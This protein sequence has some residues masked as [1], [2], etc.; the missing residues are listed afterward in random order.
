MHWKVAW[1]RVK[2][3]VRMK[4]DTPVLAVNSD[5]VACNVLISIKKNLIA[6]EFETKLDSNPCHN[7]QN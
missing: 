6:M 3:V 4:Q 5:H 1:E 2:N 7:L